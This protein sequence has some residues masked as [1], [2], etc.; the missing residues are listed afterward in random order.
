MQKFGS[1]A[2]YSQRSGNQIQGRP[3]NQVQGK[4][5]SRNTPRGHPPQRAGTVRR[6]KF[7]PNVTCFYCLKVGYV[8]EDYHKLIGYPD[9]F[10]FTKGFSALIRGNA[11][12]TDEEYETEE[13]DGSILDQ[14]SKRQISQIKQIFKQGNISGEGST[15]S[16]INANVVAG[17]ITK[18]HG[19]SFSVYNSKAG[20]ID[21][22]A[23]EHM[24]FDSTS[25][26]DLIPLS[27]PG[28]LMRREQT[29]GEVREEPTLQPIFPD[30]NHSTF[31]DFCPSPTLSPITQSPPLA[32]RPTLVVDT[33]IHPDI[34]P[35]SPPA[36]VSWR[37]CSLKLLGAFTFC[38]S[39]QAGC[40][41][42]PFHLE[43]GVG[44]KNQISVHSHGKC[45]SYV[46]I[47][48]QSEKTNLKQDDYFSQHKQDTWQR[49]KS[50]SSM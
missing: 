44:N 15:S 35:S 11:T 12:V 25:F 46:E 1:Q 23:S 22:G 14:L 36:T 45:G 2:Q 16:G 19:S 18:H 8:A 33:P 43:G 50:E 21:S 24:C 17:T 20:I 27:V 29:F 37:I 13:F 41:F 32:N 5:L 31:D 4:K 49:H 38:D 40:R 30:S 28:L 26:L 39:I 9:D 42:S 10:Q 6:K 48:R 7:N 47:G 3:G 34:L